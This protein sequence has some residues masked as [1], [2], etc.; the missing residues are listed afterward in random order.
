MNTLIGWVKD[1][2]AGRVPRRSSWPVCNV[3]VRMLWD[4]AHNSGRTP[5]RRLSPASWDSM[6][7]AASGTAKQMSDSAEG[8]PAQ[9]SAAGTSTAARIAEW[10]QMNR[11]ELI[12]EI[13]PSADR[14]A[15]FDSRTRARSDTV[16]SPCVI[17]GEG[18][19]GKSVL[20]G[21]MFDACADRGIVAPILIRCGQI[22]SSAD[23]STV[24]GLDRAFGTAAI[25]DDDAPGIFDLL[26]EACKDT[27]TRLLVD[28]LDLIVREDNSDSIAAFI[29]RLAARTSLTI[30]CREQE[31]IDYLDSNTSAYTYAMPRLTPSQIAEWSTAYL[32]KQQIDEVTRVAFNAS[33]ASP[34]VHLLVSSPLRLAMACDIYGAAGA[35]PEDLTV[36]TLYDQYWNTRIAADRKGRRNTSGA[37]AQEDAAL[38][39][40]REMWLDQNPRLMMSAVG[41]LVDD[42]SGIPLLLSDGIVSAIGRRY[43]FFHQTYAEFAIARWLRDFGTDD[44]LARLG[45][46]LRKPHGAGRWPIAKHLTSMPMSDGRHRHVM[47]SIPFASAEGVRLWMLAALRAGDPTIREQLVTQAEP[48]DLVR[49]ITV[50]NDGPDDSISLAKELLVGCL[51][52]V[53][54]TDLSQVVATAGR[55]HLRLTPSMRPEFI[56]DVVT[57]CLAVTGSGELVPSVLRRFV[58]AVLAESDNA[59]VT[60]LVELYDSLPQPARAALLAGVSDHTHRHSADHTA[61]EAALLRRSLAYEMP[62]NAV[63]SA[64]K[65]LARDWLSP[66]VAASFNWRSWDDLLSARLPTRWDSCQ[67]RAVK[68]LCESD[69]SVMNDVVEMALSNDDIPRDRYGNVVRFIADCD[70]QI[71]LDAIIG[72]ESTPSRPA[73]GMICSVLNHIGNKLHDNGIRSLLDEALASWIDVDSRA[74]WPTRI[75]LAA[76]EPDVLRMHISGL[77]G[78]GQDDPVIGSSIDTFINACPV[79]VLV[80]I[81][82][83]LRELVPD[84]AKHRIRRARLDGETALSG[85]EAQRR[86]ESAVLGPSQNVASA[87]ASGLAKAVASSRSNGLSGDVVEWL[88]TLIDSPNMKAAETIA[89]A[90]RDALTSEPMAVQQFPDGVAEMVATRMINSLNSFDDPQAV[91]AF[92]RLLIAIDRT[93]SV[94]EPVR[95]NAVSMLGNAVESLLPSKAP[96]NEREHL[97]ALYNLYLEAMAAFSFRYDEPDE[98]LKRVMDLVATIDSGLIAGRSR[99]SLAHALHAAMTRDSRVAAALEDMWPLASDANKAAIIESFAQFEANTGGSRS[100][101]LAR[102]DDCPPRVAHAVY[103]RFGH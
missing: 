44:D 1:Q 96:S 27:P 94:G 21:Q 77:A 52:H 17:L 102:R 80:E 6:R 13:L 76:H 93:I 2:P 3:I 41:Q 48:Q 20:L 33:V 54:A 100:L 72:L 57:A 92:L 95:S 56:R 23:L 49:A 84:G 83:P 16:A 51:A 68:S 50:L 66:E 5:P 10:S 53:T 29:R 103:Q 87:A 8:H 38:G 82:D 22:P 43:E 79:P 64:A 65:L 85:S 67:I 71:V 18:G 59:T 35:V 88:V 39:L 90:L 34:R 28:T 9:P 19:L 97:P 62:T 12:P 40:A 14:L 55:L 31:W 60:V 75:K 78:L 70:Q 45:A 32:R 91:A 74:I 61:T 37:R 25:D 4:R 81:A 73:V 86:T 36:T 30:T 15:E 26:G 58:E 11:D 42:I 63:D 7:A 99:R 24:A 46:L 69:R 47:Q 98:T 89:I 101:A